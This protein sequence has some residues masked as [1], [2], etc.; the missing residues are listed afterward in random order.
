[1]GIAYSR[2]AAHLPKKPCWS[3]S[4]VNDFRITRVLGAALLAAGLGQAAPAAHAPAAHAGNAVGWNMFGSYCT[5]CHNT[6]DWAGGVAFD[7]MSEQ[8]IPDNIEVLEKAV[9]KLRSQQMPPRRPQG[10][11]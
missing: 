10:A 8:D 1:M 6:E 7:T 3:W 2:H 9:R 4:E 11:G 5:E